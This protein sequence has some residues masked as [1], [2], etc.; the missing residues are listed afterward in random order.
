MKTV[1]RSSIEPELLA[2]LYREPWPHLARQAW[3]IRAGNFPPEIVFSVPGLRRY[4]GEF[5]TN[6]DDAFVQISITGQACALKCAHCNGSLLKSMVPVKDGRE[7]SNLGQELLRR[8]T[9]GVL[10][11]GGSDLQGRVPLQPFLGGIKLLKDAGL[12]VI[13]HSGLIDEETAAGLKEACVDQVLLDII[14]CRET[15]RQVYHL[16]KEPADYFRSLAILKEAGLPTVPHIVAGLHYGQW[17]GELEALA[18][19]SNLRPAG[20]VIVVLTPL[21]GTEM[22]GVAPLPVE[23]VGKLAAV[24]RIVNP[25]TPVM[26]GCALPPR[27]A[28]EHYQEAALQAG[29]NGIAYPTDQVV[30]KARE[31]GLSVSFQELCCSLSPAN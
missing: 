1:Q 21:K 27:P 28:K 12:K 5:Y 14:G 29:V 23:A 20:I 16:A 9:Q 7:L 4:E 3:E 10:I 8:K 24:A 30:R 31:Q 19:I 13:V 11:S 6:R 15:I 17:G 2:Q 26:L 22:E 25:A 18:A